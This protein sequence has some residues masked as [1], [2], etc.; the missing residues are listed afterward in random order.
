MLVRLSEAGAA[1]FGVL[2]EDLTEKQTARALE[3]L[4]STGLARFDHSAKSWVPTSFG[5][6]AAE[7]W[8]S[9]H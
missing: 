3:Q 7:S 4:K 6:L 1:D 9:N 5:L 2:M 8:R